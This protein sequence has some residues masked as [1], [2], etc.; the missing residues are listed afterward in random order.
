M[1]N[2]NLIKEVC[3]NILNEEF[4]SY[5]QV[6]GG[7]TNKMF[8]VISNKN[9]YAFKILNSSSNPTEIEKS[10]NIGKIISNITSSISA[11]KY[12]DK[13]VQNVLGNNVVIYPWCEGT[14]L[15][16]SDMSNYHMRLIATSLAKIHNIP[17]TYDNS[18]NK[19]EKINFMKY[20]ELLKDN[21]NE[22]YKIF[23]DKIN[24]IIDINDKVYDAY[25]KLKDEYSYVHKDL[26]R[27]NILWNKDKMYIIDFET[28][29]IDNP[30]TDFFN[31]A[32]FITDDIDILKFKTF[33]IEYNK[34]RRLND[35]ENSCKSAI[36]NELNWLE[37][38][39]KRSLKLITNTPDE[40]KLGTDSLDSSITE[41]INYYNKIPLMIDIINNI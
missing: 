3:N 2:I 8:K 1:D 35:I 36:I 12:N 38:S 41:I 30:N 15:K 11:I 10:E 6:Y 29:T 34:I 22:C 17:V 19:Y 14:I 18:K 5:E 7:I 32:W 26:N 27:K 21:N 33:Y 31:T 39:L 13:Y 25:S 16:H 4:I 20:Y 23:K 28:A 24:T 40:V 37:F 9:T